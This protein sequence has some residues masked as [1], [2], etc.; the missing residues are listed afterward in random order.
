[1]CH[2]SVCCMRLAS[3]NSSQ[4]LHFSY[5]LLS[6]A[7]HIC[8][9]KGLRPQC[10]PYM[11][12]PFSSNLHICTLKQWTCGPAAANTALPIILLTTSPI[13]I[14]LTPGHLSRATSLQA[15]KASRPVE[16][17]NCWQMQRATIAI[18]SHRSADS[19]LND[20]RR[21]LQPAASIPDG[22]AAPL[23]LRAI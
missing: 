17:T 11:S 1:M 14:G 6:L 4:L 7:R 20:D 22:P 5:P 12:L 18:A 23:V 13:P 16:S 2:S 21:H 10:S 8:L 15:V 9:H 3:G 19:F